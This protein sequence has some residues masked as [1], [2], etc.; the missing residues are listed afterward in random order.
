MQLDPESRECVEAWLGQQGSTTRIR[1]SQ[2]ALDAVHRLKTVGDP[3]S[4]PYLFE[5]WVA[6]RGPE[7]ARSSQAEPIANAAADAMD[8]VLDRTSIWEL[9][10]L[11]RFC[12]SFG[13]L[14]AAP[15]NLDPADSQSTRLGVLA[16]ASCARDGFTREAAV[17][18]LD[19]RRDGME[20]PYLILR[21]N[22]WVPQVREAAEAAV[23]SR[24][25]RLEFEQLVECLPLVLW[26]SSAGRGRSEP[27]HKAFQERLST[28][29]GRAA[30]FRCFGRAES[31]HRRAIF[32]FACGL[33]T[34]R[35]SPWLSAA[36]SVP[37]SVV[38]LAA[39][40]ALPVRL[41][42]EESLPLLEA[43]V[44]D[45]NPGVRTEALRGISTLIGPRCRP[46]LERALLDPSSKVRELA[47]FGLRKL[48]PAYD[49]A[50]VYRTAFDELAAVHGSGLPDPRRRRRAAVAGLGEVG[51]PDDSARVLHFLTGA[52]SKDT[53]LAL[54]ALMRLSLEKN[55]ETFF[56]YLVDPR[57]GVARQAARLLLPS[58]HA[59]DTERLA[60]ILAGPGLETSKR[61]VL[62]LSSRLDLWGALRLLLAHTAE[63]AGPYAV[64]CRPLIERW[65]H[66]YHH[67]VYE[68]RRP[69]PRELSEL[70]QAIARAE[71]W[72]EAARTEELRSILMS[73]A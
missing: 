20:L 63:P 40:R 28:D 57:P 12:R 46:H 4:L 27:L 1:L 41:P 53:Q 37:D 72:L 47:R 15:F 9:P 68:P 6:S 32:A 30:L 58:I 16:G 48:D 61:F 71:P 17:R 66:A 31:S 44:Q 35:W 36:T 33:K 60:S 21:L 73:A 23:R 49:F 19:K 34:V 7:C 62:G 13:A 8:L 5:L 70:E 56:T 11:D 51:S 10:R 65:I 14:Y 55:R 26:L 25:E 59:E 3:A 50:S 18:A 52:S 64:A 22:D 24:V 29:S 54:R 38:R 2:A 43:L 45:R 39:C 67:A 42:A 69:D